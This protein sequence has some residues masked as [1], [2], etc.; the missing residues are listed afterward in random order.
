MYVNRACSCIAAVSSVIVQSSSIV[1]IDSNV[2]F[3]NVVR[4]YK[5]ITVGDWGEPQ[6][7]SEGGGVPCDPPG[8][9]RLGAQSASGERSE[10]FQPVAGTVL[11]CYV[12]SILRL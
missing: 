5:S 10:G 3:I 1:V 9:S 2:Y 4:S 6:G 7:G 12:P 11:Q 8:G